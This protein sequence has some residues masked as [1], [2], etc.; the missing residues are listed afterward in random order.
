[1]PNTRMVKHHGKRTNDEICGFYVGDG[2]TR[3]EVTTYQIDM[4]L[5]VPRYTRQTHKAEI[6]KSNTDLT[7]SRRFT[8]IL[9]HLSDFR[10]FYN[11]PIRVIREN[12]LNPREAL[13]SLKST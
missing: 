4:T 8:R 12:P 11:E 5:P 13:E 1:M 2:F 6:C 7:D 10:G 3:P 9:S